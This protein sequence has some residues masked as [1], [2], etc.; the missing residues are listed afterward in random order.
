MGSKTIFGDFRQHASAVYRVTTEASVYIVGFHE[1]RGR[2]VVVVRGLPGTDREHVVLRDSDPRIGEGSMFERLPRDWVGQPMTVATMTSSTITAVTAELDPAIIGLVGG[3]APSANTTW[4]RAMVRGPAAELPRARGPVKPPIGVAASVQ[5]TRPEM[6]PPSIAHSVV[7]GQPVPVRPAA[8][9]EPEVPYPV[10]HVRYAEHVAL[11]L[12]SIAR[13]DRLFDD[14]ADDRALEARLRKS[15]DECADLLE[16][17]RR[18]IR[19]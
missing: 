11:L 16:L 8:A 19:R 4:M 15:L 1:E 10:R 18:R 6:V 7:V 2:T 12:R 13:R 5:G 14:V 3:D 9:P 17:I